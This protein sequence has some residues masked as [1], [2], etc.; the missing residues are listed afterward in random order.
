MLSANPLIDVSLCESVELGHVWLLLLAA[1]SFR[2]MPGLL[3][4]LPFRV[5]RWVVE[6]HKGVLECSSLFEIVC[7][8]ICVSV[9]N[10]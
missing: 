6:T 3:Y 2:S 1:S 4:R 8:C 10:S 7:V 9:S 5:L